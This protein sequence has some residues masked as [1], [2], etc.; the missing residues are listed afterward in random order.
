MIAAGIMSGTSLDGI[1]VAIADIRPARNRYTVSALAFQTIPYEPELRSWLLSVLPPH[2]GTVG[3]VAIAQRRLGMATAQALRHVARDRELAYVAMHGQTLYHDGDAH[4][5]LQVGS[6]FFIRDAAKTTVIFDFRS[7]DCAA[8]G[9]G[10]PLVPYVDFLLF[11]DKNEDRIAV[12]IGGI[13]NATLIPAGGDLTRARAWDTGPGNMLVDAFVQERTRGAQ[14][15]DCDG[16]LACGGAV[17]GALLQQMLADPYFG[18]AAPKSTGREYF[19][20]QFLR[21]F[22]GLDRLSLEDGAA[23]LAALTAQSLGDAILQGMKGGRVFVSGGGWKNVAIRN[24]LIERLRGFRVESSAVMGIEVDAKEAL[25]FAVLGYETL[26]GRPGN[27]RAATGA[28]R[29]AVLGAIAP[30]R[31][32]YL[33]QR[34]GAEC[35]A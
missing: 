22:G 19:G 8:G 17:D 13:A 34:V 14:N 32:D 2:R 30:Y 16:S 21:H 12:N 31:L 20:A 7:A 9:Q 26:R 11:A 28:S 35:A 33:L 24:G 27:L 23:T 4:V 15:F 5:T 3:D 18:R 1:D 6:P 29:P 10:A 25:A